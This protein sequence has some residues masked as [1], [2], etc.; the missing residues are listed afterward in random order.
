[1]VLHQLYLGRLGT[2]EEV[3]GQPTAM[4]NFSGQNVMLIGLILV[5]DPISITYPASLRTCHNYSG[6]Y[7]ANVTVCPLC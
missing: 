4:F 3:A 7:S 1:M 6:I 5:G 2:R